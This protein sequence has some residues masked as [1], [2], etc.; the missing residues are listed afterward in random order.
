MDPNVVPIPSKVFI[1]AAV[2]APLPD[3]TIH[4]GYFEAIDIGA[5]IQNHRIDM[6]TSFG[7]QSSVFK[8]H[9][10]TNMKALEVYLVRE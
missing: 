8:R 1:P 9:G 6:F 2:G 7:D 3:G 4:D 5:A 10:I